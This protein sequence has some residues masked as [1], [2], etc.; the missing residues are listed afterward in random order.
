[1]L[2]EEGFMPVKSASA[3]RADLPKLDRHCEVV[4]V[5]GG[6]VGAS[7]AYHLARKGRGVTLID[8][9]E[10]CAG[11]SG[12][13]FA[14]VGAHGQTPVGYHFFRRQSIERYTT[15]GAELGTD[16]EYRP[17]GSLEL[18]ETPGEWREAAETVH[19][20]QEEGYALRMVEAEELYELEPHIARRFAGATLC[21][22]GGVINPFRVTLGFLRAASQAGA[23]LHPRTE[24]HSIKVRHGRVSSLATSR[25]ELRPRH[26]V[27][28]AGV[29]TAA[30]A[31]GAGI[32]IPVRPVR[33]QVLV[34]EPLPPFF[35]HIV[36]DSR[37][38]HQGNILIGR[39]DEEGIC[40]TRTSADGV[41]GL[42]GRFL[43]M[44]PALRGVR[45]IRSYAGLRPMPADELPILGPL[46]G[47]EGLLVAVMH[48]GITLA[49]LA[50]AH[51]DSSAAVGYSAR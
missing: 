12:A 11:T 42:A 49:P 9:E 47:V 27:L 24:L 10:W 17:M 32:P 31:R 33:G 44:V 3:L 28:A 7:V 19:R 29:A 8:R 18:L 15:L 36:S 38:T 4:V 40:T 6:A 34:T 22:V 51:L 35:F 46:R 48:S 45:V 1:L 16:I 39:T 30:I 5:G 41:G 13:T 25:G 37:Q 50:G 43:R 23:A 20:M 26:V 2:S 21:P 14:W